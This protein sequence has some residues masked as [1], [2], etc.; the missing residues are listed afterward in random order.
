MIIAVIIITVCLIVGLTLH[1]A[2]V[3][4]DKIWRNK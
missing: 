4:N 2:I 3:W 1:D